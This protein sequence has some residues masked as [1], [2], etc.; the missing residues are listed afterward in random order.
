MAL[1][2]FIMTTLVYAPAMLIFNIWGNA[3]VEQVE[4]NPMCK[5]EGVAQS[6]ELL[7]LLSIYCA[8]F[9]FFV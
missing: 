8:L 3:L 7:Y 4:S 6:F 9:I 2:T 5:F 1:L